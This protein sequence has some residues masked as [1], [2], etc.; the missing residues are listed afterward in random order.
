MYFSFS[1]PPKIGGRLYLAKKC[2]RPPRLGGFLFREN[3]REAISHKE[4]DYRPAKLGLDL[5]EI[6]ANE[7]INNSR[8][9]RLRKE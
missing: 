1:L 9:D 2:K 4:V 7:G 3:K 5:M 8:S 6:V